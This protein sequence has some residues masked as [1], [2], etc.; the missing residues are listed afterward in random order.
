MVNIATMLHRSDNTPDE[1]PN[2]GDLNDWEA[3]NSSLDGEW[4]RSLTLEGAKD[5]LGDAL[6]PYMEWSRIRLRLNWSEQ[7]A[8]V[9]L[10][11]DSLFSHI[12][13]QLLYFVAGGAESATCSECGTLY[14]ADRKPRR[15]QDNYCTDCRRK[16]IPGRNSKRRQRAG[17]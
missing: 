2:C 5:G 3:I 1:D 16:G 13:V 10:Q 14:V 4:L 8:R 12:V 9:G 6:D 15:D 11:L 7:K 17:K